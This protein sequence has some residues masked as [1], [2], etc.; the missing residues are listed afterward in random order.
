MRGVRGPAN[1][2]WSSLPAT[3]RLVGQRLEVRPTVPEGVQT[4]FLYPFRFQH[5]RSEEASAALTAAQL[6]A[7]SIAGATLGAGLLTTP[8]LRPGRC[9]PGRHGMER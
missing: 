9:F 3:F 8:I 4:R 2:A 6:A 5:G 1:E 7:A